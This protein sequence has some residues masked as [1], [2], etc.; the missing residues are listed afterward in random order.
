MSFSAKYLNDIYLFKK[1]LRNH[2]DAIKYLRSRGFDDVDWLID[3]YDVG[4]FSSGFF[5]NYITIPIFFKDEPVFMTGRAFNGQA[6]KHK[7]LPG[8]IEYF[9][10]HNEI[11]HSNEIIL[12]EAP[13]DALSLLYCDYPA[14][15]SL[16]AG[17]LPDKFHHLTADH[18]II[19]LNDTDINESG[20]KGAFS[21]AKKLFPMVKEV[22]I[23]TIP[24]IKG[25]NK[26][27]INDLFKMDK[28]DS[29]NKF[30]RWV[31]RIIDQ[32]V[33]F[34]PKEDVPQKQ[35]PNKQYDET[36]KDAYDITDVIGQHV[37]LENIGNIYR[38]L[39]PFHAEN[40]PSFTVYPDTNSFFCFS[41]E[42]GGSVVDF[43]MILHGYEF[44]EAKEYLKLNY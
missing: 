11:L 1:Q 29:K 28:S 42:K 37:D 5:K 24:T 21:Q 25:S 26:T 14:I 30:I 3:E 34:E 9:F 13:L 20:Q 7:H 10:N 8:K 40:D 2:G 32:A 17:K 27:D 6:D 36:W 33:K 16:G 18:T 19:I 38:G 4:C 44:K 22:K 35:K 23:G 43:I 15:S 41:C 39:C 31:D 12:T